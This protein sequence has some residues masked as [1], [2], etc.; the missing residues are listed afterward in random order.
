M[1]LYDKVV[2]EDAKEECKVEI[3]E[4]LLNNNRTYIDEYSK[5]KGIKTSTVIQQ[6]KLIAPQ[7]PYRYFED[8]EKSGLFLNEYIKPILERRFCNY[9]TDYEYYKKN[10]GISALD[11]AFKIIKKNC[12][13]M[14]INL[15][16]GLEYEVILNDVSEEKAKFIEERLHYLRSPRSDAVRR[17]GIYIKG[18]E[19]PIFY[20]GF[21]KID[22]TDKIDA[23][24]KAIGCQ[25]DNDKILELSRVYGYGDVTWN[26]S[27]CMIG[28]YSRDFRKR[29]YQYIITAVNFTLGFSGASMVASG[30]I[31]YAMRPV[32]YQYDDNR[33][34]CTRRV[35]TNAKKSPNKMPPNILFVKKLGLDDSKIPKYCNMVDIANDYSFVSSIE[36]EIFVIRKELEKLWSE[37]TRYHGIRENPKYISKGQCGVSSLLLA[38]ILKE[39]GYD[40]LF[41]EGN[42][43]FKDKNNADIGSIT[44]HCWL[45][46][47]EYGCRKKNVII[48]ITADQ[49][50]YRKPVI[51]MTEGDL[52]KANLRYDGISEKKPHEVKISHLMQRVEY[53][54]N[55]RLEYLKKEGGIQL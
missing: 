31:P 24:E 11:G 8:R 53:L 30:F 48:D 16:T 51:F 13:R 41:C 42:A 34:Y 1:L 2:F 55:A 3:L 46:I 15:D 29:G 39:K 26:A 44:N 25:I 20:M 47:K 21:S 52:K 36:H 19:W 38:K 32:L 22:R 33:E 40:V 28:Y 6:I 37:K 18:Y 23:L 17:V 7:F 4:E 12:K 9:V 54:E 10:A 35:K 27:S 49:N 45:K 14:I 43:Y 5:S 50:G